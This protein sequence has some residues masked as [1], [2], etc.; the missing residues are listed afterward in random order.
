M[1]RE[2]DPISETAFDALTR[3]AVRAPSRRA[4]LLGLGGAALAAGLAGAPVARAG[5]AGKK[6]RKKCRRQRGQCVDFLETERCV[7]EMQA[8]RVGAGADG[9]VNEDCLEFFRPCCD[10]LAQCKAGEAL[11]CLGRRFPA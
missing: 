9:I 4:A 8:A 5:K 2:E 6:A 10:P 3:Q 11:T 1:P 7:I